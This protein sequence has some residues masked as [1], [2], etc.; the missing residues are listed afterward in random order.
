MKSDFLKLHISIVLAGFTG[1]FGKLINLNEGLLV[2]YRVLIS[3]LIL[4]AI[5]PAAGG[6]PKVNK[7]SFFKV[8]G[9]GMLLALHFLFFYGSITY[10]NVS[11][12]VVC[13]SLVGFF[14]AIFEPLMTGKVFNKKELVYS[15]IAVAGILLIFNLDVNYRFGIILG[16]I[17]SAFAALFTIANKMVGE[18][19]PS[20]TLLFYEFLG[21]TAF[22]SAILPLYLHFNPVQ[23]IMPSAMDFGYLLILA[24][25]CTVGQYILHIQ[26]LKTISAFTVSLSGNLEPLYGIAIAI[27]F[28]GEAQQLGWP[29]YAGM[30]LIISSVILQS[31]DRPSVEPVSEKREYPAYYSESNPGRHSGV[32]CAQECSLEPEPVLQE[33]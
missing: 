4:L 9:T 22:M 31:I 12:G 16:V 29:F 21:A 2:W 8:T 14:T 32:I 28:L 25:F 18:G 23:T 27:C 13:Y 5:L 15:L 3:F 33:V 10:S 7:E 24:F 6:L 1:I 19:K 17:A 11:V 26:A 30:A 20:R